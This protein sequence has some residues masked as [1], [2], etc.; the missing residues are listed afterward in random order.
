MASLL[1]VTLRS[2][3]A[4]SASSRTSVQWHWEIHV[5]PSSPGSYQHRSFT[6][7]GLR[8]GSA[9]RRQTEVEIHA[10]SMLRPE[11]VTPRASDTGRFM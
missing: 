4:V 7:K 5:N 2:S 6:N 11:G 10:V 1:M 3:D 8:R 9:R